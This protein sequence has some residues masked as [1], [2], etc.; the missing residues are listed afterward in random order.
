VPTMKRLRHASLRRGQ[1][2]L[3]AGAH[4][5]NRSAARAEIAQGAL[6]NTRPRKRGGV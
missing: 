2:S 4:T 3:A 5:R 6:R 1:T